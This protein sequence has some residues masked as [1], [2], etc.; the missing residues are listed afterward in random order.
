ML[1]TAIELFSGSCI[2]AFSIVLLSVHIEPYWMFSL[3]TISLLIMLAYKANSTSIYP[4]SIGVGVVTMAILF[5]NP[6]QDPIVAGNED[7]GW[8]YALAI[9]IAN[10]ISFNRLYDKDRNNLS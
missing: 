9:T 1:K 8:I 4:F 10:P 6:H 3:F 2:A 7:V 5:I